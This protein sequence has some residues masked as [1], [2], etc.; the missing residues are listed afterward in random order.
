MEIDLSVPKAAKRRRCVNMDS[1]TLMDK[2][3]HIPDPN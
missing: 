1:T 2:G 3:I